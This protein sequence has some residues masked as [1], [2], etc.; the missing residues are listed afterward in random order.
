MVTV[1]GKRELFE[2]LNKVGIRRYFLQKEHHVERFIKG[3]IGGVI[4]QGIC[5]FD[6][7]DGIK[8]SI[9]ITPSGRILCK[10]ENVIPSSIF[11]VDSYKPRISNL[12]DD[13]EDSAIELLVIKSNVNSAKDYDNI[14]KTLGYKHVSNVNEIINGGNEYLIKEY[15]N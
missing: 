14:I 3:K 13:I 7:G 11:H 1:I 8:A 15:I 5:Y 12:D 10:D 2:T 6:N 4:L 9:F